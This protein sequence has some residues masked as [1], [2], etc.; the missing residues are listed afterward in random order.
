MLMKI[1][2]FIIDIFLFI[3][4]SVVFLII[5]AIIVIAKLINMA[6]GFV[7]TCLASRE[8]RER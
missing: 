5:F 3:L 6:S 2:K 7:L 8:F 1:L 4:I